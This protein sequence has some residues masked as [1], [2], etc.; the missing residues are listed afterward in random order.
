MHERRALRFISK[1]ISSRMQLIFMNMQRALGDNAEA[2]D[3]Y[4]AML[5]ID[6]PRAPHVLCA[7]Y[8]LGE[9]NCA[10]IWRYTFTISLQRVAA[11][12]VK[13]K[14][15]YYIYLPVCVVLPSHASSSGCCEFSILRDNIRSDGRARVSGACT[16]SR[17]RHLCKLFCEPLPR[18]DAEIF[19]CTVHKGL[20]TFFI[21]P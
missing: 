21:S 20:A 15:I 13:L 12:R 9:W 10:A 8:L 14:S 7:N 18:F 6:F 2:A 3:V 16:H 5:I 17:S 11:V 19:C 4:F 1:Q